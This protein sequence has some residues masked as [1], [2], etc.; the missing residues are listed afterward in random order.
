MDG[1]SIIVGFLLGLSACLLGE[2]LY[3]ER[4][5]ARVITARAIREAKKQ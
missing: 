5:K 3:L 1:L 2:I 4:E